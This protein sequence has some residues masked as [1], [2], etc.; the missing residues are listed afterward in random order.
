MKA[1]VP[2][3][4]IIILTASC[5]LNDKVILLEMG[6]DDYITS[7]REFLARLRVAL[8]HT[9]PSSGA[10]RVAFDGVLVDFG[11]VEVSRDG[12]AVVLTA[13][14]FK[15]LQFL[16]Q[17]PDRLITRAELLKEVCGYGDGY[18]SSRRIDNYI[19]KRGT[20]WKTIRA[21]RPTFEQCLVWGIS[22]PSKVFGPHDQ[23]TSAMRWSIPLW[24]HCLA[25]SAK[26]HAQQCG[27]HLQ[28]M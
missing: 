13:H 15:T 14:E 2:S 12:T 17:N 8:R 20:S 10:S 7:P 21:V 18:T 26:A 24:L 16:V 9:Q 11:K 22:S 5:D 1:A 27:G 3:I 19:M 23:V 6:A 25:K 28:T 4:P